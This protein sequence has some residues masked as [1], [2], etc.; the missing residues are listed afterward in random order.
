MLILK[1]LFFYIL[2]IP[3]CNVLLN[4]IINLEYLITEKK[5]KKLKSIFY[6]PFVNI[7]TYFTYLLIVIIKFKRPL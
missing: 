2:T 1:I 5:V 6:I 3:I 7:I 4:R